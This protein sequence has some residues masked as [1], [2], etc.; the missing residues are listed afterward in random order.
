MKVLYDSL[1]DDAR[2]FLKEDSP[3]NLRL[4][5]A[6]GI[7]P[8]SPSSQLS[9]LIYLL[10]DPD[11]EIR[12][13][14]ADTISKMPF[15]VIEEGIK[16]I[17]SPVILNEVYDHLKSLRVHKLLIHH[18]LIT[19]EILLK[20]VKSGNSDLIN[21][22]SYNVEL[23]KRFPNVIREM[24][25]SPVLQIGRREYLKEIFHL[26]SEFKERKEEIERTEEE[27]GEEVKGEEVKGEEHPEE[28]EKMIEHLTSEKNVGSQEYIRSEK[29]LLKKLHTL[30]ASQK[31]KLAVTGPNSIR[32]VLLRDPNKQV[33]LAALR[34]PKTTDADVEE[35]ARSPNVSEDILREI[36]NNRAWLKNYRI[37]LHLVLN[38]KTPLHISMKLLRTLQERDIKNIAKDKNVPT[39]LAAMAKSMLKEK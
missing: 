14:S 23:L 33:A 38:P 11:P 7:F 18:K 12:K 13:T 6:K 5:A 34:S 39:A 1:P 2:S 22:L 37:R 25:N 30:T 10:H 9:L 24:I 3:P 19:E 27:K 35:L 28:V 20:I 29:E 26:E 15:E 21:E 8:L 36:A 17:Q 16:E 31:V 4:R 32:K